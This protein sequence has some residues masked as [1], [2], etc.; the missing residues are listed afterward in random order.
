MRWA[1]LLG[2]AVLLALFGSTLLAALQ[3]PKIVPPGSLRSALVPFAV[4]FN[5]LQVPDFL[6]G[7]SANFVGPT[8]SEPDDEDKDE[9]RIFVLGPFGRPADLTLSSDCTVHDVL[10]ELRRRRLIPELTRLQAAVVFQGKDVGWS[11]RL[12]AAGIHN[13]STLHIRYFWPGGSRQTSEPPP[14][15]ASSPSSTTF[16]HGH[17]FP[18]DRPDVWLSVPET[19]KF[20]CRLCPGTSVTRKHIREHEETHK[21]QRSL[22]RLDERSR[23]GSSSQTPAEP[24]TPPA[25]VVRG[26]LLQFLHQLRMQPDRE[27]SWVDHN[28]GTV[29]WNS[30]DFMDV[31]THMDES[32]DARNLAFLATRLEEYI[33]ERADIDSDDEETER[34]D[35][36][37]STVSEDSESR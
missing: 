31:D 23:A 15:Q 6:A 1:G 29:D 28:T 10:C 14:T 36:E 34:S 20:S 4:F 12:E 27:E 19:S 33:N 18:S 32:L 37:S 7:L 9:V 2:L 3:L 26:P 17:R 8:R 16:V 11:S 30:S 24:A 22:A 21:H 35:A 5:P 13:L 25:E